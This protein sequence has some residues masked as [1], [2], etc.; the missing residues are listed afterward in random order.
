MII[1]RHCSPVAA[2]GFALLAAGCDA[3]GERAPSAGVGLSPPAPLMQSRA[4]VIGAL[5]PVVTIDGQ[6]DVPMAPTGD[7]TRWRGTIDVPPNRDYAL[8]VIWTERVESGGR[9]RDLPLARLDRTVPVDADGT[10][11]TL[12]T[13]DGYRYEPGDGL[14]EE[15]DADGDGIG[16]F[17][18]RED[19]SDP[20]PPDA[21]TDGAAGVPVPPIVPSDDEEPG[22]PVVPPAME[23]GTP[24]P[25][26]VEP[27]NEPV[28][29]PP[30]DPAAQPPVDSGTP[31]TTPPG[32]GMPSSTDPEPEPVEPVETGAGPETETEPDTETETEPEPEPVE[33]EPTVPVDLVIPRIAPSDAPALDGQNVS[34]AGN[35][36]GGEWAA[37]T[38]LD[39][40][41]SRLFIDRLMVD[42]GTDEMDG[43]AFRAWGAMHDGEF[44][45]VVVVVEDDGQR[46]R[47]DTEIL[48]WQDDSLEVYV[49]GD[50]SKSLAYG[51]GNDSARILPL[52]AVGTTRT[53]T[54]EGILSGY[55]SV[56]APIR[57]DFATG[58][59]SG[60]RGIRRPRFEQDVYELRIDLRSA[61]IEVGRPFGFE[62]QVNDDDD[63]GPRE[64][65]WGWAHPSRD[66]TDTDLTYENP[67]I[68]GTAL[69]E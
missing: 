16:N 54:R 62:L 57:I 14:G 1:K 33:P 5:R 35:G 37:A 13:A 4:I 50:N 25:P 27:T 36:F 31:M 44:L 20:F 65:K 10:E 17:K 8:T 22:L 30:V 41:G 11:F 60:P 52:L 67:S 48:L 38:T 43:Q 7:G 39:A 42:Q 34:F 18:E 61:G 3:V 12:A 59:G 19:G 64:A 28:V 46:F 47:D 63:G 53:G 26:R 9:S 6:F 69:L 2:L 68:M 58:P 29:E 51:D 32:S 24:E 23:P 15:L 40:T 21:S 56:D 45:Y 49:D 66:G 55:L